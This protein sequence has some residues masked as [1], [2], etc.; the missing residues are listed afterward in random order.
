LKGEGVDICGMCE[1]NL[2]KG[3]DVDGK[4]TYFWLGQG[5]KEDQ[6]RNGGVGF[7]IRKGI[8][9]E[10]MT[11]QMED[12]MAIRIMGKRKLVVVVVYQACE[13]TGIDRNKERMNFMARIAKET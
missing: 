4:G 8:K 6:G 1:T 13:G 9:V 11:S 5:R 12:L 3:Q 2:N 7:L 10:L